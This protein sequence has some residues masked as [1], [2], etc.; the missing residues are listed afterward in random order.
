METE[1]TVVLLDH[2]RNF[3]FAVEKKIWEN[4]PWK[5]VIDNSDDEYYLAKL[6]S[7]AD[8]VAVSLTPLTSKIIAA[9]QRCKAIVR[10]G[11][12]VDTICVQTAK[13]K[14]IPVINFPNYCVHEVAEHAVALSLSL[15]RML[16]MYH[17]ALQKDNVWVAPNDIPPLKSVR[18]SVIGVLG[19]GKTG[20]LFAQ[21]MSSLGA[22]QLLI[23][24]RKAPESLSSLPTARWEPCLES[25]FSNSDLISLHLPC[26][27]ET[28]GLINY[29]YLQ[30]M[31]VG[32]ILINVS[33]GNLIQESDL[34]KILHEKRIFAGLD[35]FTTEPLPPDHPFLQEEQVLLSPHLAWNSKTALRTLQEDAAYAIKQIY[36]REI[37]GS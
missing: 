13:E 7:N 11:I 15:L 31:K 29:K 10:Y 32:S 30:L 34:I 20:N 3:D 9:M 17:R 24:S 37:H 5:I 18:E 14:N 6:C 8:I 21:K 36:L 26:N 16:P 4:L 1:F 12:G 25:I 27:A 2:Q 28:N 19:F 23:F 35:V 22:K 33:R